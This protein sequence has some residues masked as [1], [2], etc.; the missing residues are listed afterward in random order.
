MSTTPS[1]N[2]A[3]NTS[4][5]V[6]PDCHDFIMNAPM[7]IFTSTPDG[8]LLSANQASA[9]ALGFS[10][11]QELIDSVTDV[12]RQI[13]AEAG[14]R[15]EFMRLM[16]IQGEVVDHECRFRRRDGTEFWVSISARAVRDRKGNITLF[17]GFVIDITG[18]KKVEEALKESRELLDFSQ[19][20]A[21]IGGW[22]WDVVLQR[23]IWTNET[24]RIYGLKP[25]E[26]A[27]GSQEHIQ[28]SRA[29]YDPDDRPVIQEAFERCV[30]D[31]VP[32]NLEFPLNTFDGRRIWIKT[33]ARPVMQR[34]HV[35]KVLGNVMDIT[36]RRQ[37]EEEL[38]RNEAKF[39]ALFENS[40]DAVFLADV[41]TGLIVDANSQAQKLT[42]YSVEDLQGMHQTQLHPPEMREHARAAFGQA[43]E[44]SPRAY[45]QEFIL[46]DS[47]GRDIP[48]E[49]CS[50]GS[51]RY[52]DRSLHVGVFR[53]IT[54]RKQAEHTQ[55]EREESF[56]RLFLYAPMPYQSLDEHGNF[57][58]VNQALLDTLGYT[59][60]EM[61]GSNFGD[62]LHPDW[63]EYFK[64]NFPLYKELGEAAGVEFGLVKKDGSTILVSLTGKVQ[65]DEHGRFQRTHCIFQDITER[66]RNEEA[67]LNSL[68]EKEILL[69]EVHH[70][71]K[72]NLAIISAL[73][74][75]QQQTI[76]DPRTAEVLKDLDTRIKSIVLVHEHLYHSKNMARIDFQ[77]YLTTLLFD[78]QSSF[79]ADNDIRCIAG[80]YGIELGL[81]IAI[82]CGMI[83]NELVTNAFKH[84]FPGNM[85]YDG[86]TPPEI[87][88]SMER[89]NGLYR[90]VVADNGAGFPR[91]IDLNT[92]PSF[93]LRLIR[94]IGTHQL[95]GSF[96]LNRSKGTSITLIFKERHKE[97]L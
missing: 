73:L 25:G 53:D 79:G 67:L 88:V 1:N 16:K 5:V 26:I 30:R 64:E 55:H 19:R 60:E 13:Y 72:N 89:D 46:R 35:V 17:H 48:V 11:P 45:I 40:G 37:A 56:R 92:S 51:F 9:H 3:K 52:G 6:F 78:L 93:G 69:R 57:I 74:D 2:K 44:S 70:R 18:R 61:I 54:K 97:N 58:D 10:T 24:Y 94:M 87:K 77:D 76:D 42:G 81:D 12:S 23:M 65:L 62:I 39:R 7:G 22:E 49:I 8:R 14:D 96:E 33:M 66:R 86:R 15:D 36:D 20:L 75:M 34:G 27:P 83:I 29:C 63:I 85:T 68:E 50:G 21:K 95:Q 47:S 91:E 90:I 31:G 4:K 32:Y 41:D 71:V 80:A 28:L 38:R 84:A 59:R 82:P 43:V